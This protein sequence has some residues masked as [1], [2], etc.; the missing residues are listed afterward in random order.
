MLT[1]AQPSRQGARPQSSLMSSVPASPGTFSHSQS[2]PALLLPAQVL[3]AIGRRPYTEGLGLKEAGVTQDKAGRIVVDPVTFQSNVPG[4][5]AIGDIVAGPMLA[6]KAE[7][8]GMAVVETL[9]GRNVHINHN[10]IPSIIYT[11]PEVA[12]VGLTEEQAKAAGHDYKVGKFPM[13]A[14][15]RAR[16]NDTADGA[17]AARRV[18]SLPLPPPSAAAALTLRAVLSGVSPPLNSP[19]NQLGDTPALSEILTCSLRIPA[20]PTPVPRVT[21]VRAGIVKMIADKKTDKLL[22]VTI[23]GT[24]AGELIAECVLAME[25]GASAEDIARTC[26]GHPTLSEAVKEAALATYEKA[27]V[28]APPAPSV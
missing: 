25:Y 16:T 24:N 13:A 22:G 17:R 20:P 18:L 11:D 7:D 1:A 14:N 19:G 2:L 9:A 28:R 6:H 4:I 10:T 26:H 8:E 21:R 3:V 5:F 12:W 27:I 23:V 15:S